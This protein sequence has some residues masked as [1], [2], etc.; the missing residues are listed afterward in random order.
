MCRTTNSAEGRHSG[1]KSTWRGASPKLNNYVDWL[2]KAHDEH[3]T[4]M[5][6]LNAGQPLKRRDPKYIKLD[7]NIARAKT[8]F[9]AREAIELMSEAPDMTDIILRHLQHVSCLFGYANWNNADAIDANLNE[10]VHDAANIDADLVVESEAEEQAI[11]DPAQISL[12]DAAPSLPTGQ[13]QAKCPA[14]VHTFLPPCTHRRAVQPV[15]PPHQLADAFIL[16]V[17]D[18]P[19]TATLDASMEDIDSTSDETATAATSISMAT[20]SAVNAVYSICMRCSKFTSEV[21]ARCVRPLHAHCAPVSGDPV[22]F[23]DECG[24]EMVENARANAELR[25]GGEYDALE[26]ELTQYYMGSSTGQF[27]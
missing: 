6:Q 11:P 26:A 4:R 3:V 23:C 2:I 16:P 15:V 9:Q 27:E 20:Q 24:T 18:A 5:V 14:L 21:C 12:F 10:P 1:L 7:E 25:R 22:F 19:T 13:Q 17:S 8:R